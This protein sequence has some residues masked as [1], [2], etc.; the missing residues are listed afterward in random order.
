MRDPGTE[1]LPMI[2]GDVVELTKMIYAEREAHAAEV[3]ERDKQ[4]ETLHAVNAGDF[5]MKSFRGVCAD[6]ARLRTALQ[7]IASVTCILEGVGP[8]PGCLSCIARAALAAP[9]T[10][11]VE[12]IEAMRKALEGIKV[13]LSGAAPIDRGIALLHRDR[14]EIARHLDALAAWRGATRG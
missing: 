11:A 10:A 5:N 7:E 3:A 9:P 12:A 8:C 1:P 14:E 4:I 6:N 13:V 2:S